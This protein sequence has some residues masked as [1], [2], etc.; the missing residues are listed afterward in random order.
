MESFTNSLG[1]RFVRLPAGRFLMGQQEGGDWDERPV[2]PVAITQPFFLAVTEVTNAQ[3]EAFDPKHR[4]LRGKRGF[5]ID[6]QENEEHIRCM[7]VPVFDTQQHL[8]GG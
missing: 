2:H 4:R 1:M 6:D 3:Y 7:A 8:I 5:S